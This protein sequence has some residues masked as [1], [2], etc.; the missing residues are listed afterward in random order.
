[1]TVCHV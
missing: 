1:M